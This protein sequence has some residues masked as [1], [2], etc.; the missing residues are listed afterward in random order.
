MPSLIAW[1]SRAF[2]RLA[3][4]GVPD[5]GRSTVADAAASLCSAHR[6]ERRRH[7][8]AR[9]GHPRQRRIVRHHWAFAAI[10]GA[11]LRR[12]GPRDARRPVRLIGNSVCPELAEA[13]VRANLPQGKGGGG[14]K[15]STCRLPYA[16]PIERWKRI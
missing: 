16:T 7:G 12:D 15:L 14:V 5:T 9:V 4:V 8:S 6:S 1:A 13:L 11:L 2:L 3:A 10:G